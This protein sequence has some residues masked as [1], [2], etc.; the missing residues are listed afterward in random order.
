MAVAPTLV[1]TL[2]ATLVETQVVIPEATLEAVTT[3]AVVTTTK[4]IDSN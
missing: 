3:V 2:E 1:E 4:T